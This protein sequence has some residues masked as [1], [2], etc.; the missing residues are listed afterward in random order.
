MAVVLL[1]L[2]YQHDGIFHLISL[3]AFLTVNY[4]L[5]MCRVCF[6]TVR[7]THIFYTPF[8]LIPRMYYMFCA[9]IPLHGAA[10]R[11][12][13]TNRGHEPKI[14]TPQGRFNF[15]LGRT[16]GDGGVPPFPFWEICDFPKWLQNINNVLRCKCETYLHNPCEYQIKNTPVGCFLFGWGARI[17]TMIKR[18]KISCPTIRRHPKS[19]LHYICI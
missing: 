16:R 1:N 8:F 18:T 15:W 13:A 2:Q 10:R 19:K 7:L 6:S 12:R 17:R 5:W 14:K 4:R 11:L 3:A 9:R